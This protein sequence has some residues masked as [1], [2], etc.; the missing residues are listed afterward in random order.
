VTVMEHPEGIEVIRVYPDGPADDLGILAG[1][2]ILEVEGVPAAELELAA[3]IRL[4]TGPEG[5][6]TDIVLAW[7]DEHGWEAEALDFER[8]WIDPEPAGEEP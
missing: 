8:A 4:L 1:D 6:T 3:F 2:L 5:T 7:E